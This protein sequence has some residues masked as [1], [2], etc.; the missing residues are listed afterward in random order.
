MSR[1]H[2][3]ERDPNRSQPFVPAQETL[4]QHLTN[5]RDVLPYEA[6]QLVLYDRARDEHLE[7]VRVD[8]SEESGQALAIDFPIEWPKRVW[9]SIEESDTLPPTIGAERDVPGSFQQSSIFREVLH[10]E[11]FRDGL[12]LELTHAG[13]YTGLANFSAETAGIYT[14]ELRSRGVALKGILGHLLHSLAQE[15]RTL[16]DHAQAAVV[17]EQ[18]EVTGVQG[19]EFSSLVNDPEFISVLQPLFQ[20]RAPEVSFLWDSE[21][22]WHRV[23]VKR[24]DQ[25][26]DRPMSSANRLLVSTI[27]T[28]RPYQLT[29][30]E[31]RIL[32]YMIGCPS[33]EAIAVA[34]GVSQRTVHT[35][36]ANVLAKMGCERRTQAVVRAVRYSLFRPEAHPVAS[37]SYLAA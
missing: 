8:Y 9:H 37:L 2:F 19:R 21:R 4:I 35:H 16:P 18:G 13:L 25:L 24:L 34:L 6:A 5:L 14:P 23:L 33:N 22:G 26:S 30:A 27:S 29:R 20:M 12:T 11:G 1:V 28:E 36:V 10:P 7:V 15:S 3:L 17:N 31:L 32:T